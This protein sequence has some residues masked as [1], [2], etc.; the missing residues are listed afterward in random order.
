MLI[1]CSSRGWKFWWPVR[2]IFCFLDG[3]SFC[4]H[5]KR[6]ATFWGLF[7]KDANPI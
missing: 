2:V 4:A 3:V 6:Q 7:Y 1:S 5:V